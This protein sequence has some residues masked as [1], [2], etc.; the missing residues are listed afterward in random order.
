METSHHDAS[1]IKKAW[2]VWSLGGAFYFYQYILRA[3]PCVMADHIMEDFCIYGCGFGFLAACY[4]Y[5]YS[6]L[7]ISMGPLLDKV[8][9]KIVMRGAILF[10][11]VGTLIFGV[12]PNIMSASIGRILIGAGASAAFLSTVRL[13]AL[14]FPPQKFAFAVGLA[15]SL[16]TMG[17]LMANVPLALALEHFSWRMIMLFLAVMGFSLSVLIWLFVKNGPEE[18]RQERMAARNAYSLFK[19]LIVISALRYC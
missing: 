4:F 12:A 8:G 13:S 10:C 2:L 14:W 15:V 11:S 1:S 9:P 17:G 16:G 3:S 7:Q 19:S 6:F 5:V 18:S